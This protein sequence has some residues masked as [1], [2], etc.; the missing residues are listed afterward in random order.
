MG[1]LISI[2]MVMTVLPQILLVFDSLI[3]RTA[4]NRG[5]KNIDE[6]AAHMRESEE[7]QAAALEEEKE[8][9]DDDEE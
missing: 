7:A 8:G 3:E 9:E 4:F 2:I 5:A 1:T 6:I